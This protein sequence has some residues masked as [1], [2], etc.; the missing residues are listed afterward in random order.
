MNNEQFQEWKSN[1][2]T[3]E[4]TKLLFVQREAYCESLGSGGTVGEEVGSTVILTAK[5]VGIIEGL[6]QFL[7][8]EYQGGQ[9]AKEKGE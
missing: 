5:T 8:M 6:D 7:K 9:P 2:T 3:I 1:P 4:V